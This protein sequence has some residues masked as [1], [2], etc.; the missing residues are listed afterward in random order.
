VLTG[1]AVASSGCRDQVLFQYK[2]R[3]V[4][5]PSCKIEYRPGPFVKDAS[6][7]PVTIAGSAFLVVRCFPAYTYQPETGDT[8]YGL[9]RLDPPGMRHVRELVVTG[10]F[11][12]VLTWVIGLDAR[13]PFAIAATGTPR[14]E[15]AINIS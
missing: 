2:V 4:A 3:G 9:Q 7:A 13:R 8:T 12:G 11:E 6:G 15:L 1:V 14:K 5:P 10:S